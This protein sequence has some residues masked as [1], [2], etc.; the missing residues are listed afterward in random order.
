MRSHDYFGQY[1]KITKVVVNKRTPVVGP[2]THAASPATS[3]TGVYITFAKKDDAARAIEA[4]D[5]TNFE[6]KI[7]R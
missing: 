5:G 2:N 3:N 1:G 4:V 7:I 6:G